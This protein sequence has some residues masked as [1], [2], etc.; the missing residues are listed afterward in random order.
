MYELIGVIMKLSKD[1]LLIMCSGH[2]LI[3]DCV[4]IV[5]FYVKLTQLGLVLLWSDSQNFCV[6][7]SIVGMLKGGVFLLVIKPWGLS[8]HKWFGALHAAWSVLV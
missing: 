2:T 4:Y 6:E 5:P 8:H 3:Q 1:S 7:I